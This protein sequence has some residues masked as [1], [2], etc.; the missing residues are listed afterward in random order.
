MRCYQLQIGQPLTTE[1]AN[2]ETTTIQTTSAEELNATELDN[3]S[4]QDTLTSSQN[5]DSTTSASKRI[6]VVPIGLF[7]VGI[8][9]GIF[10]GFFSCFLFRKSKHIPTDVEDTINQDPHP[11]YQLN[12]LDAPV[13]YSNDPNYTPLHD[14]N[15]AQI[16]KTYS[17]EPTCSDENYLTIEDSAIDKT[18][19]YNT[20][21]TLKRVSD[22]S[23]LEPACCHE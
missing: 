15:H 13:E 2:I 12:N 3:L 5:E 14:L 8:V 23:Y 9:I 16:N 11:A 20:I 4:T 6:L 21:D 1:V 19:G 22:A 18:D 17:E 7:P 10:I